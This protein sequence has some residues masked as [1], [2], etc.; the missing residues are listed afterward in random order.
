MPI[1]QKLIPQNTS[2]SMSQSQKYCAE[3][4]NYFCAGHKG[5]FFT[6]KQVYLSTHE[7]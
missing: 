7:V 4:N 2:S 5:D 1:T 6:N 3:W